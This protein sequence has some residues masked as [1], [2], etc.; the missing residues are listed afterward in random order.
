MKK[1]LVPLCV[2]FFGTFSYS[3]CEIP[4]PFSGN[5]GSNMTV[6]LTESFL[7]SLTIESSD[8]YVVATTDD[9]MVVGSELVFGLTQTSLAV[10]GDDSSTNE[11]D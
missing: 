11:L 5:T 2:L 10:W 3:Q 4:Q 1:L 7:S 6:M 9:G 8:A